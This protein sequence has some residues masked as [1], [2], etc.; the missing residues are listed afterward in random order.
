MSSSTFASS[1]SPAHDP[2]SRA[3]AVCGWSALALLVAAV[4]TFGADRHLRLGLFA[5]ADP[6]QA[7]IALHQRLNR[8]AR[9]LGLSRQSDTRGR[10]LQQDPA[11]L[12][13]TR[14]EL[15]ALVSA[16]PRMP[17][18]IYYQAVERMASRDFAGAREAAERGLALAPRDLQ[19]LMLL[20][21][22][23]AEARDL[24]AA[25]KTFRRAIEI[26]PLAF[27]AYDNLGQVLWL[28]G[29][30]DEAMAVYRKRA[31][32]EGLP[33]APPKAPQP[34]PAGH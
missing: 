23:E 10:D 20:G 29:R 18:A 4:L 3:L 21:A 14:A 11:R 13:A 2:E 5:P 33:L 16:N 24:A 30:Q 31:E 28:M 7:E 15:A 22:A 12:A 26:Q 27:A 6:Q 25:E 9:D 32:V 8:I 34:P 19:F 17:R 1:S